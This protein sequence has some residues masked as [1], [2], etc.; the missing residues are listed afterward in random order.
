MTEKMQD[1]PGAWGDQ[2]VTVPRGSVPKYLTVEAD[3]R[4]KVTSGELGPGARLPNEQD[5]AKSYGVSRS[6]VRQALLELEADGLVS[7]QR[8]KGTFISPPKLHVPFYTMCSF[9]EEMQSHDIDV[10]ST[11]LTAELRTAS[12]GV[13]SRLSVELNSQCLFLERLRLGNG[14][15]LG[16]DITWIHPELASQLE[17]S[18]LATSSLFELYQH[19]AGR[20]LSDVDRVVRAVCASGDVARRLQVKP[21]TAVLQIDRLVRDMTGLVL[22]VQTRYHPADRFSIELSSKR[23][24]V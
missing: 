14:E 15:V 7:R 20:Q 11:V 4:A 16:Y 12:A 17:S 18:N 1:R 9:T 6:V 3:I 24:D 23:T 2:L 19:V 8:A 10:E 13:C 22:D 21:G 5:M